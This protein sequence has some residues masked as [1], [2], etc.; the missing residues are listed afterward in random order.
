LLRQ[1]QPLSSEQ[2]ANFLSVVRKAKCMLDGLEATLKAKEFLAQIFDR[3]CFEIEEATLDGDVWKIT[4]KVYPC[5]PRARY[6]VKVNAENG[7]IVE[8]CETSDWGRMRGK[9]CW[10]REDAD[11]D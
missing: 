5:H 8:V 9:W 11:A 3:A 1:L 7:E 2:S 10:R 4:W 6:E